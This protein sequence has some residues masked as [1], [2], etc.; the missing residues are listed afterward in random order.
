MSVGFGF[1]L[2]DFKEAI[3]LSKR[4]HDGIKDAPDDIKG[5]AK[6]VATLH[7]VLTQIQEDLSSEESA[8]KAHGET[9]MK[10]L[11]SMG[12]NARGTLDELQGFINKFR[13]AAEPGQVWER[14]K[15]MASQR[16]VKKMQQDLSFHV[17]SFN[18]LMAAMGK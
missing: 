1:S 8:L 7:G 5:I 10:L 17:S 6:D 2:A 13:M 11:Q 16:K 14:L 4:L 15:W 9:R 18:L 3:V 12:T